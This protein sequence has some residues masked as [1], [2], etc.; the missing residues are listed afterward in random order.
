MRT[1]LGIRSNSK[2]VKRLF[3]LIRSFFPVLLPTVIVL[4]L[5][6]A[7]VSSI[8]SI[9]QQNIIAIIEKSWTTD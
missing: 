8:P 7:V 1:E 5:I 3:G 9:F 6:N 2:T 4:I